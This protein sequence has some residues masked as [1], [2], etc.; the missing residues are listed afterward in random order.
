VFEV[1]FLAPAPRDDGTYVFTNEDNELV[2]AMFCTTWISPTG[3]P[4]M[5]S[6]FS[7]VLEGDTPEDDG[8]EGASEADT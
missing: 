6:I 3:A 7:S 4:C 2:G 8:A 1:L 5:R